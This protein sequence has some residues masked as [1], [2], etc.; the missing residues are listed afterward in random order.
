MSIVPATP[1]LQIWPP[2]QE[3]EGDNGGGEGKQ[4]PFCPKVFPLDPS[5]QKG[6]ENKGITFDYRPFMPIRAYRKAEE[7]REN[8]FLYVGKDCRLPRLARGRVSL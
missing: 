2:L 4:F 3:R 7:K 1:I 8:I 6:F 5:T